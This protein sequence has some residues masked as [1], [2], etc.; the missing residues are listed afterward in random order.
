[1]K[2][3]KL[4]ISAC[5]CGKNTKYNG[6]NNLIFKLPELEEKF[7]LYLICP[8]VMGGMM[9]P[10]DPSEIK[11][12]QVFSNKGKN[13]SKEFNLGAQKALEVALKNHIHLALLKESSPSCGV[14]RVYDGSFSGN[15]IKGQGF[16]TKLLN[17]HGI[18]IFSEDEIDLLL[19][20]LI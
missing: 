5:L 6:E 11:G 14:H 20:E 7:D 1:M 12:Q 19:K 15:K 13:V 8:E 18:K 2:K 10:R 17:N 16:T 9:T 4:L 3:T